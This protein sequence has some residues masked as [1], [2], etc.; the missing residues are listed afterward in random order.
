MIV[1]VNEV[2]KHPKIISDANEIIYIEDKRKNQLKSIVIPAKYKSFLNDKLK[3]IEYQMWLD[4]NK[5]LFKD[6]HPKIL[7]NVIEDIGDKL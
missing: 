1:A 5:G 7:D 2:V 6:S 4:R 3:E